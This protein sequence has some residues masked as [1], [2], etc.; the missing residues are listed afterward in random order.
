MTNEPETVGFNDY[1]MGRTSEEYQRLRGQAR[2]WEEAT[3]RIL[4]NAGLSAGMR[5]LDVGC[6]AGDVMRLMGEMVGSSGEV[7]GIDA[8]GA[9]GGE[10]LA[11]LRETTNSQFNFVECDVETIDHPSG[12]PFDLVFARLILFHV[13]D[14][15]ALLRKMYSWVK[16][17]GCL[18][19]QDYDLRVTDIYPRLATWA[20][21]ELILSIIEKAR[22]IR[23][24][25]KLPVYFAEAG[26]G[27]VDGTDAAARVWPLKKSI[28]QFLGVYRGLLPRALQMGLTTEERSQAFIEEINR[29]A[30]SE[31]YYS[32]LLPLMIGA[33]KHKPI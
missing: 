23:L 18:V 6:G 10:A 17:G 12:E 20:E 11:T 16:P 14:P 13:A 5:C 30:A 19:A 24:G 29:A 7:I 27:R 32:T 22:D 31:E 3:G 1:L 21:F 4:R 33:W 25:F 2:I 8:D 15:L 26:L 28:E 9:L